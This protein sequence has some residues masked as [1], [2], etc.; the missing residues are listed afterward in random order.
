MLSR[1]ERKKI[2][3]WIARLKKLANSRCFADAIMFL[4]GSYIG[5]F[6]GNYEQATKMLL[7]YLFIQVGFSGSPDR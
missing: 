3:C 2:A 7:I 6:S 4:G 5:F 1:K